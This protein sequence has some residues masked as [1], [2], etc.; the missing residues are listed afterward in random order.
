MKLKHLNADEQKWKLF[1]GKKPRSLFYLEYKNENGIQ[2]DADLNTEMYDE[3]R[4]VDSLWKTQKMFCWPWLLM[5]P[6]NEWYSCIVDIQYV[7]HNNQKHEEEPEHL[8]LNYF[9]ASKVY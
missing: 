4:L 2:M 6:P 8:V 3:V 7:I 1:P 9:I 5:M